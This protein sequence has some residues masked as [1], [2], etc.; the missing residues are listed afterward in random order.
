MGVTIESKRKILGESVP[1]G[2]AGEAAR[3][4]T[5]LEVAF[6][7]AAADGKLADDEIRNLTANMQAWLEAD[8]DADFFVATFAEL[9]GLLAEEGMATRLAK[10][11]TALDAD[12]RRAAYVLACVTV[13][14]DLEVHDEELLVL[15]KIADAFEIPEAEAQATFDEIEDTVDAIASS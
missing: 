6:I 5:I 15:G 1:D 4:H 2:I 14:C 7:A 13:L 10:A 11:A 8:L 12:S 9:A 3:L